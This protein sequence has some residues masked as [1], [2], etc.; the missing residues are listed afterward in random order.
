MNDPDSFLD[1]R[2]DAR[3][4][5]DGA[6]ARRAPT[7]NVTLR[8]AADRFVSRWQGEPE[9]IEFGATVPH[10][11]YRATERT[12]GKIIDLMRRD[13][14]RLTKLV[15][16]HEGNFAGA[17]QEL[18]E[19]KASAA[20]R[21]AELGRAVRLLRDIQWHGQ[22]TRADHR[23]AWRKACPLCG[24]IYPQH[25]ASCELAAIIGGSHDD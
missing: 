7:W 11:L 20:A 12:A 6:G 16:Y 23:D 21:D 13:A 2:A 17:L 5:P 1:R 8:E 22:M 4:A 9:P 18:R 3:D 15:A 24:G 25:T 14:E 19:M 10:E